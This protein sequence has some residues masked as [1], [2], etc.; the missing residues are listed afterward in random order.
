LAERV[1]FSRTLCTLNNHYIKAFGESYNLPTLKLEFFMNFLL[2]IC[3]NNKK[4]SIIAQG[5]YDKV[6]EASYRLL[7]GDYIAYEEKGEI[8]HISIVTGADSKGYALVNSHNSD[9]YRY[10]GTLAGIARK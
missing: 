6:L 1:Y 7:A 4:A 5:P 3:L 10:H 9:R 2:T 8:A